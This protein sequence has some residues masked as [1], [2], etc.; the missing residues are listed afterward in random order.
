[1]FDFRRNSLV[2]SHQRLSIID[3][4]DAAD[5]P[6][7][8]SGG[9]GCLVYNGELYNYREIREI[10]TAT[11]ERFATSSDTEVLLAALHR[12]GAAQ[13]LA[14]FNWMGAFAWVDRNANQL[15][16]ARDAGSEKPLY[17]YA[18]TDRI[19]FASELKTLLCLA[20][21]RFVL[22]RDTTGQFLFQSLV[23]ASPQTFLEGVRQLPAGSFA[24]VDLDTDRFDLRPEEY[25]PPAFEG[26]PAA[27][28]LPDLIDEVR[29]LFSDSVRLR[30]RSDVP[31]GVL[32]SGGIDSSSIAVGAQFLAE[33]GEAP[34]LLSAISDDPRFDESPHIAV[35]ERHLKRQAH[36]ITLQAAPAMLIDELTE[37]NWFNDAPVTGMSAIAHLKLMRAA[38]DLGLKVILSGQGADEIL[39]GY[40]KFLGFYLQSLVRQRRY[41]TAAAVFAGFAVNR[42]ILNQFRIADA[43]RYFPLS[44]QFKDSAD[45]TA[46]EGDWLRGWRRLPLGLGKGSLADRQRLDIRHYS[47]PA[48]CHYE[49]RMSMAMSR[50]IRLPF[51]DSRLVDLLVR[52]PDHY[53]LSRGWTK[54]CLREAMKDSLPPEVVWR[55]DKKGFTNPQGEWLKHEL[56]GPVTEAFGTDSRIVQK[57]I[58][59]G[60]ALRRRYQAYCRQPAGRGSIWYREVFGPL[61]LELW[62]R[63]YD[64]WIA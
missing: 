44:L 40:R 14:Q 25:Q 45:R 6:M 17:Y 41:A 42:S 63:R 23:D 60:P 50:E 16:L 55:R 56:R 15:V 52:A 36:K 35:M 3:L 33:G 51:L 39:L 38:K 46:L 49:D 62:L 30:L 32:L 21:R 12:W 9:Q 26:D 47:V 2:L 20:G 61:S 4:S 54:Y 31:V 24:V 27:M 13:A 1:M 48:L 22:D 19:I 7:A 59:D 29:T 34:A 43:K 8:Y 58:V 64:A 28:T 11:G 53:K 37:V 57:G 5:Q 18:A 10:L